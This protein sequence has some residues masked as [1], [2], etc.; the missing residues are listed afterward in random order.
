MNE[1]RLQPTRYNWQ[2]AHKEIPRTGYYTLDLN[3]SPP[4]VQVST[5]K[6]IIEFDNLDIYTIDP[7]FA[8]SIAFW[9]NNPELDLTVANRDNI[10]IQITPYYKPGIDDNYVPYA[11][12]SGFVTPDGLGITLYNASS[13]A[14]GTG[15][16][17]GAFY[18]YYEMYDIRTLG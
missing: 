14:A 10:Y 1:F 6:G 8:T 5:L 2:L 15:Q 3:S 12:P 7:G 17:T 9:I 13:L 11:V 16:L 4:V 18:L